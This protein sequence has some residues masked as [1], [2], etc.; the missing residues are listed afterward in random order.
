MTS[1]TNIDHKPM[2]IDED[3][4]TPVNKDKDDFI[5]L[6]SKLKWKDATFDTMILPDKE[7]KMKLPFK[8]IFQ[9]ATI[10]EYSTFSGEINMLTSANPLWWS[11]AYAYNEHG[12]VAL[13]PNILWMTILHGLGIAINENPEKYRSGIVSHK[14][15]KELIIKTKPPGSWEEFFQKMLPV[16]EENCQKKIV[17][18]VSAKFSTTTLPLQIIQTGYIMN[19]LKNYFTYTCRTKCGIRGVKFL[20]TNQDWIL[21]LEKVKGIQTLIESESWNK[22]IEGMIEII[23]NLFATKQGKFD[24][25]WWRKIMDITHEGQESGAGTFYSGWILKLFYQTFSK[26][27][28]IDIP[29][30]PFFACSLKLV[31][32]S[33]EIPKIM[34]GGIVG[35]H[36]QKDNHLFTP[37]SG[38]GV[39]HD[40]S[41]KVN[42]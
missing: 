15:K 31:I 33:V 5:I 41:K 13:D 7:N 10:C 1:E 27:S 22:Y 9:I 35:I 19:G 8:D 26:K 40:G 3:F 28:I 39:F 42:T 20:G 17:E 18:K 24:L 14:D 6:D 36:Y 38:L 2:E 4:I 32:G 11:L 34:K 25:T 16:L 21:L 37:I 23:T 29:S 30:Q 12:N